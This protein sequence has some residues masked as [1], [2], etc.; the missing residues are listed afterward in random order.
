MEVFKRGRKFRTL[1]ELAKEAGYES[2]A[3]KE[4]KHGF[5]HLIEEGVIVLQQS[6]WRSEKRG[7]KN[8]PK[9]VILDADLYEFVDHEYN[10]DL[11]MAQNVAS[12]PD[13]AEK[14]SRKPLSNAIISRLQNCRDCVAK[15]VVY[16]TKKKIPVCARHW[17]KLALSS[18]EWAS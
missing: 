11:S 9:T 15:P 2:V 14:V 1:R 13:R 16:I 3:M 12:L 5:N 18:I 8:H 10:V 4:F 17:E 6:G 7:G